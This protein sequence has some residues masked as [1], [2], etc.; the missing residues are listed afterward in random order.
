MVV[1]PTVSD[2]EDLHSLRAP[3]ARRSVLA[4]PGAQVPE[5]AVSDVLQPKR[6]RATAILE[7]IEYDL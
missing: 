6:A 7:Q 4:A 3:P 2:Q 1:D 5:Q